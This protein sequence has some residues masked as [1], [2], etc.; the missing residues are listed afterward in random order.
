MVNLRELIDKHNKQYVIDNPPDFITHLNY[1]SFINELSKDLTIICKRTI[2]KQ[3]A[4]IPILDKKVNLIK[5]TLKGIDGECKIILENPE[6]AIVCVSWI[7]VK[8]YYL[9][10]N[11]CLILKYL[12]TGNKNSFN[13]TH[14]S[15]L[16]DFKGYISREELEFNKSEFNKFHPCR[17]IINWKSKSGSNPAGVPRL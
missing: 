17:E 12:M 14:L 15:M 10:Y 4:N 9:L 7:S 3:I 1:V 11:L 16:E 5:L 13:S 8:A 6:Y 2:D